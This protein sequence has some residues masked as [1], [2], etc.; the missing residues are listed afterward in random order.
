[1]ELRKS[2]EV[3]HKCTKAATSVPTTATTATTGAEIPPMAAPSLVKIPEMP[4]TSVI[5]V[6][7]AL[8]TVENVVI[9]PPTDEMTLPMRSRAGPNAAINKPT[10]IMTARVDSSKELSQL[11]KSCTFFTISRTVGISASPTEMASSSRADLSSSICPGR[12]SCM[13]S[14]MCLAEPDALLSASRMLS[15][16]SG[17][18][19]MSARKPLI[20]F[21]PTSCSAAWTF[22]DSVKLANAARQSVR[23]SLSPRIEPSA[24]V[25]CT[26]TLPM[27]SP[28]ISKSLDSELKMVRSAVPACVDLMPAFDI[29]PTASAAS[30]TL[31]PKAPA[32]GAQYLK[33][34]PI[35][36]TSVFDAADAVANTSA[37]CA[38]S[39]AFSPKALS[40]PTTISEVIARS[41]PED[42]AR[43]ITPSIPESICSV[44]QPACAI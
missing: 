6:D 44:V 27:D 26:T 28:V 40:E 42:A 12:L 11:T 1:M 3:F 34:S 38:A 5:K 29:R 17:A 14:A 37:K 13:T 20:A 19:F 43:F 41:S 15:M 21:L 4:P 16:S 32:T 22:S 36:A 8:P 24:F 33:V 9:M 35:I 25:V 18:A 31:K 2:S 7:T 39:C 10:L 30:S 23:I